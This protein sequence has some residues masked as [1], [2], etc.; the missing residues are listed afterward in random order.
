MSHGHQLGVVH[1]GP[2]M[3]TDRALTG[4]EASPGCRAQELAVKGGKDR[5]DSGEP[6]H[7][8]QRQHRWWRWA[9][10]GKG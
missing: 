4:V 10:S 6:Y 8:L 7:G 5:G 1:H 2:A 9:C 3:G